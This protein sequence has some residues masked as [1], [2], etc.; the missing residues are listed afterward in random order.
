VNLPDAKASIA[1]IDRE[2]RT[3]VA[4]WRLKEAGAQLPDVARRIAP[5][6]CSSAAASRRSCWCWT[7]TVGATVA[8][9][10]CAGDADDLFYDASTKRVYVTGGDGT[11]SVIEQV[12]ADHYRPAGNVKTAPGARTSLFVPELHR[13]YVAVPHRAAQPAE[14]RVYDTSPASK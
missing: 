2:K 6:A 12:D 1:V 11:I 5:A 14:V 9:V 3:V 8:A 4:T 13:L 10:D 7:R